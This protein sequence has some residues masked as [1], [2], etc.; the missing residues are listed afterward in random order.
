MDDAVG[1][2]F[3]VLRDGLRRCLCCDGLFTRK[4]APEHAQVPCRPAKNAL[5]EKTC[6]LPCMHESA[7]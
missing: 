1:K 5:T 3:L 7:R 6:E 4:E 2:P